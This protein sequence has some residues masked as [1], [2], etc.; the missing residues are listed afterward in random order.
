[1]NNATNYHSHCSFCDGKAPLED[2]ILE[3]IRQG[4][5][6]YGISSHAPLPFPTAWTM[7]ADDIP[8]YL[9]EANA[10]KKKYADKIEFYIGME[11][12]YLNDENHPAMKHFAE[13]PLDYRIGS[14]HLL[15]DQNGEVVDIDCSPDVFRERI[16]KHFNGDIESVIRS[17]FGRIL[18]MVELGGFDILGHADKIHYNAS[19]YRPGIMDEQWYK[20]LL[21]GYF[22]VIAD[23]GCIV[24]INTKAW[25]SLHTFYPNERYFS[26]LRQLGIPVHVN[27]DAHYPDRINA[28]RR[29]AL[30]ELKKIGFTTVRELHGGNWVDVEIGPICY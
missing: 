18:R 22:T 9:N 15:Y 25:D 27:S 16:D 2:F 13:L 20:S 24:E 28:G 30:T 14:V 7:D 26:L 4:F 23:A 6:S 19:V 1:M 21:T 11:I 5:T 8:A 29:E 17:Y 12:D 3:A 10:L